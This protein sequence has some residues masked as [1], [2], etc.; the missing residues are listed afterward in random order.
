MRNRRFTLAAAVLAICQI[1]TAF[2]DSGAMRFSN[3]NVEDG[4]SHNAVADICQDTLGTM[5]FAT[6][7]GL[8]RFD[9]NGI[10]TYR[11]IRGDRHSLQSNNIHK[12][13]R[14]SGNRLWACTSNGL[15]RYDEVLDNFQRINIPGAVSIEFI[16]ELSEGVLL[17]ETRNGSYSY[18]VQKDS[19]AELRLDGAP[20]VFYSSCRNGDDIAICTRAKTVETLNCRNDSLI[21][22][23]PT[24]KIPRFGTC[25]LPDRSEP[26]SYWVGTKGEGLLKVN[27]ST[28][29]WKRV[30][31]WNDGWLEV[32]SLGYDD[33]ENLWVGHANGLTILDG[34]RILCRL[35]EDSLNDRATCSIYKDYSGGMWVGTWYGGVNYWNRG[36]DK[37]KSTAFSGFP[38]GREIVTSIKALDNGSIW[39]GTRYDGLIHYDG[40]N[41]SMTRYPLNNV[42][43]IQEGS[44][45]H[46]VYTGAEV[47]GLHRIDLDS[48]TE[49][50]LSTRRDI[51]SILPA[52]DGKLWLGTLVGL[53]LYDPV[54]DIETEVTM[55]PYKN[56]L[57]RILT[58]FRDRDGNLWVGAKESLRIFRVAEDRTLTNITPDCLK[59]IVYT[60]CIHQA[61]DGT[62]WV[63]N[64]DGLVAFS[65]NG[66][67][68]CS[69]RHIDALT[70]SAVRGIEED[71]TG[72]LW[73][74]TDNGL[75][76]YDPATG[77]N[78][79]YNSNDGLECSLFSTCAHSKDKYGNLYFGGSYGVECFRPED[80]GTDSC[81]FRTLF[82]DLIV[83]NVH[84]KPGDGSGILD[85]N[86]SLTGR[87]TLKHWQNSIT[88]RFAC[89]DM[90]SWNSCHYRYRL[91]GFDKDWIPARGTEAT[92]TKL[93][94][95]RYVFQVNAANNDGIWNDTASTLEIRIKPVWYK[96][97]FMTVLSLL[98]LAGGI[99]YIIF[100]SVRK[101]AIKKEKEKEKEIESITR[102]YEESL[103]KSRLG[104]FVD[105]Q[106]N[107]KPQDEQFLSAVLA[108]IE[109]N[110]QNKDYSVESLASTLCVSR[111]N[112][113][114]RVKSI[115]GRTPVEL[116]KTLRMQ[117]ACALLKDSDDPIAE[118]AEQLGFDNSAYFITVFKNTFGETPGKYRARVRK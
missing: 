77:R 97:T 55:P 21:R 76:R 68:K 100:W 118:V 90:I 83:N 17:V 96:S 101:T 8:D 35:S 51:M 82:T 36:R 25:I 12:I 65:R 98:L 103:Q 85:R 105:D 81:T 5:W 64:T 87:I 112:L 34:E 60:Q 14:D 63:G 92:Y 113:H 23:Y 115:T 4:M 95:G 56:R 72:Q 88:V 109:K 80:I 79:L 52:G 38:A 66:D 28:G 7:D 11:H 43:A 111:G 71:S 22:K 62:V 58:L 99:T 42:R 57:I 48:K 78:R 3:L 54:K 9:G 16:S 32:L 18:D 74:S 1:T 19:V 84:I 104:M 49:K 31:I 2:P 91:K 20:L 102:K 33:S 61:A 53:Q 41:G 44:D 27:V 107:L 117:H 108:D 46:T 69:I 50:L 89:P 30:H 39:I 86:I 37:F 73:V 26:D 106:Y 15:S 59:N 6:P 24:V 13:W 116:I 93:P 40:K 114:L 75:N 70:A 94:K 110:I 29:E 67:G 45:G 47:G 10:R